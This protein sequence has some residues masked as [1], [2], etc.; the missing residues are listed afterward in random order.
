[1]DTLTKLTKARTK[2]LLQS[3]FFS[4]LALKLKPQESEIETMATDGTHLLYNPTFVDE[5]TMDE[6]IG[7]ICHEVMHCALLHHTRRGNRDGTRWNVACDYAINLLLIEN[8]NLTL[9]KDALIDSKYKGLSAEAI[10]NVLPEAPN[11]PK[12]GLVQ[13]AKGE[14]ALSQQEAEW[15]VSVKAAVEQVGSAGNLPEAIK[16]LLDKAQAKANWREQLNRLL[17]STAKTDYSWYPPNIQ[18]IQHQ[19]HVPTLNAPSLGHLT[20]A[21]DTSASVAERELSQF[22]GELQHIL[23]HHHFESLTLLQCDAEIQSITEFEP[24][25]EVTANVYGRG[26]TRYEPVFNYCDTHS[27]DT[28]IYFTDMDP[29]EWP[30]PPGYPILWARTR[31]VDAPY[32][33]HIDIF[34][35]E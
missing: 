9:P 16:K 12:W 35:G 32:G 26:G 27:T 7:V 18:Y 28:L 33:Q 10:Y 11:E 17:T 23:D 14:V 30:A 22:F 24:G 8:F 1:M 13:D 20:L 34:T 6:L 5:L 4:T 19:L 29:C 3:C 21:I 25:D 15:I 2:L 31:D